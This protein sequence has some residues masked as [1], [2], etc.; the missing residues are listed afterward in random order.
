MVKALQLLL[1]CDH[2]VWSRSWVLSWL[3]TLGLW[4]WSGINLRSMLDEISIIVKVLD[5]SL[6]IGCRT[7]KSW[8]CSISGV[9]KRSCSCFFSGFNFWR[10]E[11]KASLWSAAIEGIQE[12]ANRFW[13]NRRREFRQG[14]RHRF[15]FLSSAETKP[16]WQTTCHPCIKSYLLLSG[17]FWV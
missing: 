17:F 2:T 4:F 13:P 7:Q 1:W 5:F 15:S 10:L 11:M 16:R 12:R 6:G 3:E 9:P 14:F 8:S